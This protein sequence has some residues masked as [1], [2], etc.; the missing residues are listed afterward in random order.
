MSYVVENLIAAASIWHLAIIAWAIAV[1]VLLFS[2][3]NAVPVWAVAVALAIA[4]GLVSFFWWG[5]VSRQTINDPLHVWG[6]VMGFVAIAV[7]IFLPL[8]IIRWRG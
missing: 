8:P 5:D 7:G 2:G 1:G 6:V 3:K 4:I